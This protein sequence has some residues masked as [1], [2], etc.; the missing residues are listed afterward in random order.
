[1]NEASAFDR[2][3]IVLACHNAGKEGYSSDLHPYGR[4]VPVTSDAV[5]GQ[6]SGVVPGQ[7]WV[8]FS[9]CKH[10]IARSALASR[11]DRK[12]AALPV[13]EPRRLAVTCSSG[14]P[15]PADDRERSMT[16]TFLD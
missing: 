10:F 15:G 14:C 4:T 8:L 3:P 1:M 2:H 9:F 13:V 11:A 16:T 6:A 5:Q 12:R 7:T